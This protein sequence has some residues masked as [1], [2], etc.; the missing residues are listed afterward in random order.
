MNEHSYWYGIATGGGFVSAL[1][2]ALAWLRFRKKD[3]AEVNKVE[4]SSVKTLAE[5]YQIKISA[6]TLIAGQWQKI[7]DELR[8]Q[9]DEERKECDLKIAEMKRQ[10]VSLQEEVQLLKNK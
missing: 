6:E 9:L 2:F 8:L 3:K 10:I 4:A 5:A 7:T 1:L